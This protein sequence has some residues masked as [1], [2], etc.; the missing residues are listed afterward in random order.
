MSRRLGPFSLKPPCSDQADPI[1]TVPYIQTAGLKLDRVLVCW[2]GS[3]SA[4]RAAGDAMPFLVQA[5]AT[6]V[7]MV[8][9]EPAKSDELPGADIAHH[10]ARHGVKVEVERIA[11]TE[12]DIAST[13]LSHAA[14]SSCDCPRHGRIRSFADA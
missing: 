14:D 7:V 13:I 2:D 11:S 8:S 1:L 4:A 5:K 10:L 9:D 3:R 6:E 12:A